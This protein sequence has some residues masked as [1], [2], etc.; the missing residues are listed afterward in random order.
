MREV[1]VT[2]EAISAKARGE[3]CGSLHPRIACQDSQSSLPHTLFRMLIVLTLSHSQSC[4]TER[5]IMP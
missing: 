2:L 5:G 3:V 1:V 4:R